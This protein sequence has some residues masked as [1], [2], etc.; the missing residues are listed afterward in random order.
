MGGPRDFKYNIRSKDRIWIRD[1]SLAHWPAI[2][3]Q[4]YKQVNEMHPFHFI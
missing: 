1:T 3:N 4:Y 2:S